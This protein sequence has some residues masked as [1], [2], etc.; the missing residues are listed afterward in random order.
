M[1]RSFD[2]D[3]SRTTDSGIIDTNPAESIDIDYFV[4]NKMAKVLD[5]RNFNTRENLKESDPQ[6]GVLSSHPQLVQTAST[7]TTAASIEVLVNETESSYPASNQFNFVNEKL[8]NG[9][10]SINNILDQ[11]HD[12]RHTFAETG[13]HGTANKSHIERAKLGSEPLI[14]T[15]NTHALIP[16]STPLSTASLSSSMLSLSSPIPSLKLPDSIKFDV[17]VRSEFRIEEKEIGEKCVELN[18]QEWLGSIDLSTG[19]NRNVAAIQKD[20]K[21]DRRNGSPTESP[22]TKPSENDLRENRRELQRVHRNVVGK[23]GE[24]I[25]DGEKII[26]MSYSSKIEFLPQNIRQNRFDKKSSNQL[27]ATPIIPLSFEDICPNDNFVEID[28][29][30]LEINALRQNQESLKNL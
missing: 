8:H 17:P 4:G 13:N 2:A 1:T 18:S 15:P 20:I 24:E 25:N 22:N 7:L 10:I 27:V 14:A 29:S 5:N 16:S 26:S 30:Q 9:S 6:G 23:N 12:V 3:T 11:E 21:L 19:G 28:D